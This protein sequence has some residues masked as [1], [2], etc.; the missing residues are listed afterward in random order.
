MSC[1]NGYCCNIV[2]TMETAG[3]LLK[4]CQCVQYIVINKLVISAIAT[5]EGGDTGTTVLP[6]RNT[7]NYTL[8]KQS[9][10]T[11]RITVYAEYSETWLRQLPVGQFLTDHYREVAALQRLIPMLGIWGQGV[12]LF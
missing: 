10:R 11:R 5:S 2:T 1:H 9:S 12:W 3:Y 8:I 4:V 7:A 6:Y